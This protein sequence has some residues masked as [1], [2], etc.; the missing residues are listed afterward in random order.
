MRYIYEEPR[1]LIG[2]IFE[3]AY[4]IK[5]DGI[6]GSEEKIKEEQN[7][8]LKILLS[9]LCD[10]IHPDSLKSY[11][12]FIKYYVQELKCSKKK[13]YKIKKQLKMIFNAI[14]MI[15]EEEPINQMKEELCKFYPRGFFQIGDYIRTTG[16]TSDV[17]L[18]GEVTY[19]DDVMEMVFFSQLN[20]EEDLVVTQEQVTD[21]FGQGRKMKIFVKKFLADKK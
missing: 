18:Y 17:I 10:G 21:N 8:F 16:K 7:Q 14:K 2:R 5:K 15:Q 4:D 11:K 6:L 20:G 3:Y 19:V 9:D 13:R 12:R 1:G